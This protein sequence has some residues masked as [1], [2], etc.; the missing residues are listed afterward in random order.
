MSVAIET[1]KPKYLPVAERFAE[2]TGVTPSPTTVSR[3]VLTGRLRAVKILGKWVCTEEDFLAYA[4][5]AASLHAPSSPKPDMRRS[6]HKKAKAQAAA[7]AEC[8]AN[9]VK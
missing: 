7:I 1:T 3:L 6:E 9:G 4:E 5:A 2:A 8:E